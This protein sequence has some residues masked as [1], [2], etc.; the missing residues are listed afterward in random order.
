MFDINTQCP[1]HDAHAHAR[2]LCASV[3]VFYYRPRHLVSTPSQIVISCRNHVCPCAGAR[4]GT[5]RTR[6][7]SSHTWMA[8]CRAAGTASPWPG[9]EREF[10]KS[11]VAVAHSKIPVAFGY[12]VL[13]RVK[14]NPRRTSESRARKYPRFLISR[15]G[16]V[17]FPTWKHNQLIPLAYCKGW[18]SSDSYTGLRE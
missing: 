12:E 10:F 5:T 3:S 18:P 16:S 8:L 13:S 9:I 11:L 6:T 1:T 4:S 2:L 17:W 15:S 7:R 14:S